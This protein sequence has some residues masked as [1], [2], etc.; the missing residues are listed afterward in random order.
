[1]REIGS[2]GEEKWQMGEKSGPP[3]LLLIVWNAIMIYYKNA[4]SRSLQQ[5]KTID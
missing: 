5:D 3:E 4:V 1:M 2:K